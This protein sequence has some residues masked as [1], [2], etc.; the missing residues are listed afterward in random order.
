[1]GIAA[2][3]VGS[4][5]AFACGA[6]FFDGPGAWIDW[7]RFTQGMNGGS[8]VRSLE[9]GNLSPAML[10]WQRSG[11]LG[12]VQYALM[13]SAWM[14]LAFV[15]AMTSLGKRTDR[16]VPSL[17]ACLADPWLALSIGILFTFATAPLVWAYYHVFALI[18]MF[19]FFRPREHPA[20]TAWIVVA[21]LAMT[22]PLLEALAAAAFIPIIP[23]IMFWGWVPLLVVVLGE[24]ADRS[25]GYSEA[26]AQ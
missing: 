12:L 9:Q 16:L 4:V 21:Y 11:S 23:I 15:L 5:I 3:A 8:L 10:L 19:A 22:N 17:L 26:S 1:M 14:G 6:A 20:R 24:V 2:A 13:I 18:P 7:F 25:Q